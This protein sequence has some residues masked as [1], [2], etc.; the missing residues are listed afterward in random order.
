MAA[1][2]QTP[3]TKAR[4]AAETLLLDGATAGS[5]LIVVGQRGH[6]LYSTDGGAN[7]RQ[8]EVPV[9]TLLTAVH[10]HDERLGWAAGHDAVVLR[11]D[12]GGAT[13]RLLHHAP[14]WQVPLLD[15]WFSD[16]DNGLAV[17]AFGL[18]LVTRDGGESWTCRNGC[19]LRRRSGVGCG[20]RC[21]PP[22][23]RG[24]RLRG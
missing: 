5:R 11:T 13:W 6:A 9:Q 18:F 15:I 3:A 23:R 8:S 19:P 2:A 17:G 4:L 21:A 24:K 16:P 10:M 12:D 7:W 1:A 14:D 20:C 22:A